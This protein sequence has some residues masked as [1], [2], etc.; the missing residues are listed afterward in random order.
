MKIFDTRFRPQT[1]E[2][3]DGIRKNPVYMPYCESSTFLADHPPRSLEEEIAMLKEL[4]VVKAVVNGRDVSSSLACASGNPGM[5]DAVDA[6]PELFIGSYGIDPV[7]AMKTLRAFKDALRGHNVRGASIDPGTARIAVSDARYY[8]FYAVCCE[9]NIPVT[10]TTGCNDGMPGIYLEHMAP[11]HSDK[12][13]TDFPELKMIISHGGY[14]WVNETIALAIRHA[15]LYLDFSSCSYLPML[16]PYFEA[17]NGILMKKT[18]FASAH[19]F[20]GL[21][22][23]LDWFGSIP[24][25]DEARARVMYANAADIFL[26]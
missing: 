13:A 20:T 21:R 7:P 10:V 6:C 8:P 15:N 24:L 19:P 26:K 14:P 16:Q 25:T 5:L 4:G 17:A 18:L 11:W 22:E 9:E 3:M 2:T 12:V 23:A 1:K